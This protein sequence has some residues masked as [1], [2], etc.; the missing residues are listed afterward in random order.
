MIRLTT[1]PIDYHALTEQVRRPGFGADQARGWGERQSVARDYIFQP[2]PQLG[3]A[4]IGPDL[5]NLAARKP[6]PPTEAELLKLLHSGSASHPAYAFL[7]T[8]RAIAGERAATAL[9]LTGQP[10][11]REVVPTERALSLVSYLLSLNNAY[12]YPEARPL[13]PAPAAGAH[14]AAPAAKKEGDKK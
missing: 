5:A 13:P 11:G 6:S 4:R 1:G 14:G 2:R 12:D 8:E 9:K 7:F 3:A 10:A